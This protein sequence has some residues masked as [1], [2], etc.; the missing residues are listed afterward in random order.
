MRKIKRQLVVSMSQP[1]IVGPITKEIPLHAV[2]WPI[3]TPRAA[4]V[5]VAVS[6]A[7]DVGTSSA[8][9]MPCSPRNTMSDV[10]PG[11]AA[12]STD[13]TPKARDPDREDPQLAEDVPQRAT[14][15]DERA[16]REEV[17][18]TIHCCAARPPPTSS[19][20]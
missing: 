4:P 5:N 19:V 13:A 14:D 3:A 16:E 8:P 11:A 1:P 18:V 15:E 20:M 12:Q 7:S 9:A 6:T 2:H 17:R 10:T